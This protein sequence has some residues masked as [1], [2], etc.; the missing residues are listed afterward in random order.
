MRALYQRGVKNVAERTPRLQTSI[1]R[2][3]WAAALALEQ[4][5][6]EIELARIAIQGAVADAIQE[7]GVGARGAYLRELGWAYIVSCIGLVAL[8]AIYFV[9][10]RAVTASAAFVVPGETLSLMDAALLS[11]AMGAWLIAAFRLQ[12]DSPEVLT[13]LFATTTSSWIRV[14][15]VLGFGFLGLLLF[16]KQVIVFSFGPN[17]GGNDVSPFTTAQVFTKLSAAVL[18]G[19]LLGLADA[20]LPSAVIARS[21]N[22]VAALTPR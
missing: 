10:T 3:S 6:P 5:I 11:L 16:Y 12:P 22:L 8:T 14:V 17:R 20:A 9:A 15:L 4:E 2:L 18:A 19:G 21:A 13:S 7:N 1:Q